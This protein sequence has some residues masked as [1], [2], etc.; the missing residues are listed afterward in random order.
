MNAKWADWLSLMR[1]G[2]W[3]SVVFGITLTTT[4]VV[5]LAQF[6]QPDKAV[7]RA[8]GQVFAQIPLNRETRIGVPGPLGETIIEIG[9][10]RARVLS[11]PSP[12]Q[13]CVQQGWLMRAGAIALCAPNQ[14]SLSLSGNHVLYDS[15]GY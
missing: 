4:G 5:W 1:P 15:L 8:A 2:D 7:I 3:L 9:Y 11:D 12:R 13:Y 10:G 14:V 6:G